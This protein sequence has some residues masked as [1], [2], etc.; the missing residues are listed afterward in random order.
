MLVVILP[1]SLVFLFLSIL[2]ILLEG[3]QTGQFFPQKEFSLPFLLLIFLKLSPALTAFFFILFTKPDWSLFYI[4]LLITF[5]FFALGDLFM[6]FTKLIGL[7]SF[8]L[9]HLIIL[10]GYIFVLITV[11]E[12]IYNQVLGFLILACLLFFLLT[13]GSFLFLFYLSHTPFPEKFRHYRFF[14]YF[15]AFLLSTHLL[16]ACLLTFI[17]FS[18]IP[19]IIVISLGVFFFIFSD[20][21]IM[22]REFY[23][24]PSKSVLLIMGPYYLAL[25]L[26]S[27]Q[28]LFL[29]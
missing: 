28:T 5:F 23:F 22:I 27:L 7:L 21:I 20:I 14:V 25:Y 6:E 8:A 3:L 19:G 1:Y 11:N 10:S 13:I 29:Y 4:L 18:T 17:L 2:Y 12:L 26:I 16:T 9:G 15:Y 24:T